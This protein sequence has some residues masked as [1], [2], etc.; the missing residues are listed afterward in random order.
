LFPQNPNLNDARAAAGKKVF[1]REGCAGCHPGP[2]YSNNKLI[3]AKGWTPVDD[4]TALIAFL[5]TL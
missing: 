4:R 5:K 2:T 1:E 3:L